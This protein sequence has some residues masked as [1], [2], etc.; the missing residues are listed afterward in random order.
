MYYIK[1]KKKD[2]KDIVIYKSLNW[3]WVKIWIIIWKLKE[4]L[5]ENIIVLLRY[6]FYIYFLVRKKIII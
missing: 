3:R 4:G 2:F 1:V 6:S 5:M